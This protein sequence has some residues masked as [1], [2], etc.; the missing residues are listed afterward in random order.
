MT[1][2]LQTLY[3]HIH[4]HTH[5]HTRTSHIHTY[6]ARWIFSLSQASDKFAYGDSHT[7]ILIVT[8]VCTHTH[9]HALNASYMTRAAHINCLL[10]SYNWDIHN[11]CYTTENIR[12]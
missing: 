5:T 7:C 6:I 3:I 11:S 1:K 2:Y 8:H 4:T 9:T 12:S 10:T